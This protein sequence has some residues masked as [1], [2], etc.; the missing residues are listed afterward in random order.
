MASYSI[1]RP[2]NVIAVIRQA[3][4]HVKLFLHHTDKIDTSGLQLEGKGKHAKHIKIKNKE[5]MEENVYRD[6]LEHV[7]QIVK[8]NV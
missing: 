8:A 7:T 5:A 3:F 4:S 6:V 2:D 1:G